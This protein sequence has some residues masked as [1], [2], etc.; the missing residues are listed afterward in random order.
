MTTDT[1][2]LPG[3]VFVRI[4]DKK[5]KPG[6]IQMP[7]D[8]NLF[9]QWNDR[10]WGIYFT[11]NS[12]RHA[13]PEEH[14]KNGTKTDRNDRYLTQ[15]NFL[16]GD[17]D[18]AKQEE[19]IPAEQREKRKDALCDALM[20]HAPPTHIIRT[21][22]GVQPL[23]HIQ[24]IPAED[25]E[26]IALWQQVMNGIIEWSKQHAA[27]G[28]A[29]KDTARVLRLPGYY[30]HKGDP[31]LCTLIP[32]YKY[33][34][35][36]E[37]LVSYFPFVSSAAPTLPSVSS[38]TVE[39][40]PTD[41]F[42]HVDIRDVVTHAYKAICRDVEFDRQGRLIIDGRL[43]G[44]FIGKKGDM[45]YVATSSG[46]EPIKGNK[47]T[48]TA[49]ILGCNNTEAVAWLR[50]EFA[51]PTPTK[52]IKKFDPANLPFRT[53]RGAVLE[54]KTYLDALDP[55]SIFSFGYAPLDSHL[56]GIYPGEVILI[57][58]E[59]GTGKTTFVTSVLKHNA[60]NGHK[61]LY[62][63]LEDT[64]RDHG[65]KELYFA[66]GKVRKERGSKNYPWQDFRNNTIASSEYQADCTEAM[67]RLPDDTLLFYDRVHARA[68]S[69]LDI[70]TLEELIEAAV[71]AGV[72]LIGIDHLH[73]FDNR[74]SKENKA[75]RIE[76]IMQRIKSMADK[77]GIAILLLAHYHKLKGEKPTLDSFKD[78]I[79]IA[80]TAN[81][82]INMW[83]DRSEDETQKTA[84]SLEGKE[85]KRIFETHFLLP[86][87]RSPAGE[88]TIVMQF[89]PFT[90][91]Y[92][93]VEGRTGTKQELSK[94]KQAQLFHHTPDDL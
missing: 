53:F 6:A 33:E 83:R 11:P 8:S 50:K 93:Y 76:E 88:A 10:Q 24:P 55:A 91:E 32:G 56:G 26:R 49:Q 82:V 1:I 87:V 31:F 34:Y 67:R 23:W 60:K 14:E 69:K 65:L 75:D 44:N 70:D 19:G 78:S 12:F 48:A 94:E 46:T 38:S 27:K 28:D 84:D 41:M 74:V 15:I 54:S 21:S 2:L 22:N 4:D 16:F 45:Q 63:T 72:R 59:S 58:G 66:I 20:D 80:Q 29:V 36:V 40:K 77:H 43:S 35:T 47:I 85:G 57:G 81:V 37:E 30:H 51:L 62:F 73:F 3:Q 79:S 52:S 25:T 13:T 17:L 18:I 86:K 68:P 7:H 42:A 71:L 61:V 89:N 92:E 90:F 64:L 39:S 5:R 9:K